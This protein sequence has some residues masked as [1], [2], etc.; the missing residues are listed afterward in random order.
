[1]PLASTAKTVALG[2]IRREI[3]VPGREVTI[4]AVKATVVSLPITDSVLLQEENSLE[5][6]P[7]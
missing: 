4:G 2:Y 3:G 7:A 1:V 5:Q 6:R